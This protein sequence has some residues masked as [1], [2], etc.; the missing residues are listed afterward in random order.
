MARRRDLLVPY[1][2]SAAHLPG[3]TTDAAGLFQTLAL[4]V[5]HIMSGTSGPAEKAA[6]TYNAASDHFDNEPLSF[7]A[8][9]GSRTVERLSL[10]AGGVILDV[11]C[12]TGASAI[13]AAELVGP[14]GKV[15]GVDVAERLLEIARRKAEA[16]ALHNVEFRFGDMRQLGFPEACFDAVVCV[17]AIF[18]APDMA[19]QVRELWRTVRPGGSSPSRPGVRACRARFLAWRTAVSKLRPDL[20]SALNPWDRIADA[21][22][23]SRLFSESGIS[24]E[25][26]AAEDSAQ[27]LRS[28]DDWWSVVLGLGYR[29]AISQMSPEVAEQARLMNR[30]WIR[31]HNVTEIETNG[32]FAVA[33]SPEN[34]SRGSMA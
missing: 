12:G 13:P 16:R 17:F 10:P 3:S 26:V 8:R 11:G 20:H 25:E 14:T 7:W 4:G 31:A 18:F 27:R 5:E 23:L 32:L 22:A 24:D 28:P 30:E 34:S 6:I 33:E 21:E 2:E 9:H 29:W 15:I 1:K 19:A